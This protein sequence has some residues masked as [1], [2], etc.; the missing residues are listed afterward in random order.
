MTLAL[1]LDGI[2]ATERLGYS[3]G[4]SLDDRDDGTIE[5]IVAALE[6][7][8]Y[9]THTLIREIALSTP[10]RH[11]HGGEPVAAPPKSQKKKTIPAAKPS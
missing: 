10:F 9:R 7:D 3:L 8:G 4:R 11:R 5:K 2:T 6:R 1:K